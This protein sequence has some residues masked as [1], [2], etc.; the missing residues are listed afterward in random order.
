MKYFYVGLKQIFCCLSGMPCT[1]IVFHMLPTA[2][3]KYC[4][5]AGNIKLYAQNTER[6]NVHVIICIILPVFFCTAYA[7]KIQIT[8]NSKSA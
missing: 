8:L 2:S 3:T 1:Y 5:Q 4:L 6:R 7:I